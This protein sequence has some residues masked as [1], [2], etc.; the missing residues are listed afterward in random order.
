M[1]ST[2]AAGNP[3]KKIVF[4]VHYLNKL[5]WLTSLSPIVENGETVALIGS[6]IDIKAKKQA[7][8]ALMQTEKNWHCSANWQQELVMK[9]VILSP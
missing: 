4:E 3:K 6:S 8:E 2:T 5:F 7:E 1:N 9:Y